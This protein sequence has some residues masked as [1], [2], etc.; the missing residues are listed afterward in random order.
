MP[1]SLHRD[2]APGGS[3]GEGETEPL[4]KLA[5]KMIGVV[6]LAAGVYFVFLY[7]VASR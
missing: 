7:L 2:L 4:V 3:R 5:K 1:N 6:G